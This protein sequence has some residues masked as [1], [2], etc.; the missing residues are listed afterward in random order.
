MMIWELAGDYAYDSAKGQYGMATRVT[1]LL[2]DRLKAAPRTAPQGG[3]HHAH[4]ELDVAVGM[5]ASR[6]A[7]T[8]TRSTPSCG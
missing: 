2:Y 8:T 7:T 5:G 1:T 3:H 6:S 4:P